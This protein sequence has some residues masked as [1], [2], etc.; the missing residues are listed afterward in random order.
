[1]IKAKFG[2]G[3]N[4]EEKERHI[5]VKKYRSGFLFALIIISLGV[6]LLLNN[7]GIVSPKVWDVLLRFWPVILILWGLRVIFGRSWFGSLVVTIISI[8]SIAFV[9]AYSVS[10]VNPNFNRI[11]R[12]Q[13]NWWPTVEQ[14]KF[15]SSKPDI[16]V[17]EERLEIRDF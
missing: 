2:D 8:V 4:I 5:Y 14:L 15:N 10:A 12:E 9:V 6:I 13:F 1:M 7:F 11:M 3:E 17:R 16:R